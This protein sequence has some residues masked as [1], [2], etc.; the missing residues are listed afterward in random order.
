MNSHAFFKCPKCRT[1]V[2]FDAS[3]L[4]YVRHRES[5]LEAWERR[6]RDLERR[7]VAR[8]AEH[9]GDVRL[10]RS[11]LHPDKHPEQSDRYTKAWQAFERLL[12]SATKTAP[13]AFDDDIPF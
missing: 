13:E 7:L 8:K 12:T 4:S 6:L 3:K 2:R 10:I 11:C 1:D 9:E 5:E